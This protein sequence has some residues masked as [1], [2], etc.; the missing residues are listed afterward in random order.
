[1]NRDLFLS[2]LAM[3]SYNREYGAGV[4][5]AGSSI[6]S[7]GIR[8]RLSLGI[9][10]ATYLSWQAAGFYAL[11][12]SWNGETVI[13]YRGTNATNLSALIT[14]VFYGWPTGAGVFA[15]QAGL[16]VDFYRAVANAV[17]PNADLRATNI[18]TTGHSLGGG[19]AGMVATLY[20]RPAQVFD[21]MPFENAAQ[22]A[23]EASI[24]GE[25]SEIRTRIYGNAAPWVLNI[26]GVSG[27]A[28]EGE[29]L[30]TARALFSFSSPF[31][32]TTISTHDWGLA[33]DTPFT[34]NRHSMD[35][36]ILLKFAENSGVRYEDWHSGGTA[37]DTLD[38]LYDN[39]V[40]TA[41]GA[42]TISGAFS[43]SGDF[44]AALRR[45]LAYSAI[46]EGERPFGDTGISALFDGAANIGR[47]TELTPSGFLAD[48][49][50]REALTK[51]I[52][53]YAGALAV[54][55]RKVSDVFGVDPN[56]DAKRG[57]LSLSRDEGALALD[58]SK[59]IWKDVLGVSTAL[60]P[61]GLIELRS[62]LLTEAGVT[63]EKLTTYADQVWGATSSDIFDRLIMGTK[64]GS[65]TVKLEKR[66]YVT[67]EETGD[68][69]HIDLFIGSDGNEKITGTDFGEL[70][71]GGKGNDR[72]DGG[73]GQD[74]LLGGDGND[75]L[76]ASLDGE[77]DI[78]D[79]GDGQDT[80]VYKYQVLQ[81]ANPYG[82]GYGQGYSSIRLL[83]TTNSAKASM[84]DFGIQI[85]GLP[86]NGFGVDTL[87]NFEKASIEA[88]DEPDYLEIMPDA[89]VSGIDYIDLGGQPANNYDV[90]YLNRFTRKVT[91][92]L[93]TELVTFEQQLTILGIPVPGIYVTRNLK[94]KGAETVF[95]GSSDDELTSGNV[96]GKTYYLWGN[97][98]ADKLTG[99]AGRDIITGGDGNDQIDGGGGNDLIAGD[100]G[101]DVIYGGAGNDR[102]E[103]GKGSNILHGGDGDDDVGISS[104]DLTANN[105]I[106]GDGGNDSLD[107]GFGNDYLDGGDGDD[108][109][110]SAFDHDSFD[111]LVG[112]SG[113]D[114][115]TVGDGDTIVDLSFEDRGVTITSFTGYTQELNGASVR[116][117]YDPNVYYGGPI[118]LTYRLSGSTLFV[119]DPVGERIT[120]LN[121]SNG[122][123]GIFIGAGVTGTPGDDPLNGDDR[124]DIFTGGAGND[125]MSGGKG[126]DIYKFGLGHGSDTVFD[127]GPS[128][129]F[130]NSSFSASGLNNGPQLAGTFESGGD[131]TIYYD[132]SVTAG[133]IDVVQ[134]SATDVALRIRGTSDQ[135]I[136]QGMLGTPGAEI[137]HV[138]FANGTAWTYAEVIARMVPLPANQAP[139]FG[140]SS[141]L[142]ASI[143]EV[144][145]VTNGTAQLAATGSLAF[146]DPDA[147]DT[148]SAMINTVTASGQTNGAPSNATLRSWLSF[149]AAVE[150]VGATPGASAWTFSAPDKTFDYLSVGEQLVLSY[151]AKLSDSHGESFSRPVVVTITGANDR[152]TISAAT[153]A[154]L[155]VSEALNATASTTAL[156][157]SGGIAFADVDLSDVHSRSVTAV[158]VSGATSG[159]PAAG[160]LLPL[161]QLGALSE[162]NGTGNAP[163]TFSAEDR[164]FD[165]LGAGQTATLTYTVRV[166]DGRGGTV[167][168]PVVV[169][170][171]GSNDAPTTVVTGAQSVRKAIATRIEG[172]IVSDADAN[173]TASVKLTTTRGTIDATALN[174]ASVSGG[175]TKILTISGSVAQVNAT[176]AGLVY[177]SATTGADT[178]AVLTSDGTASNSQSIA[179]TVDTSAVH[180]PVIRAGSILSQALTERPSTTGS[181][182]A[183]T[184][185]G[186]LLFTDADIPN[187]HTASVTSVTAS[188][189]IAGLA[190]NATVK[191][192]LTNGA[193]I[194][195]NGVTNG[196]VPWSFAAPDSSFDYLGVAEAVTL[197]YVLKIADNASGATSQTVT[198]T[199]TGSNDGPAIVTTNTV[200]AGSVT[201]RANLTGSALLDT[202]AGA[203]KFSDADKTDI[204]NAQVLGVTANGV[205]T[206]LPSIAM[207]QSWLS[208]ATLTEPSGTTAG[209]Q[210]WTFT[211][212]DGALDG[213]AAGEQAVLTYA[214][215]LSDG[216]GGSFDQNVVVTITGSN[217]K[218]VAVIK[219]GYT[220]DNA[221]A[222]SV[223]LIE[224]LGGATDPDRGDTLTVTSVQGAVNGTVALVGNNAVFT[225]TNTKIGPASFT[226]TVA[227]GKGGTSTSTVSLTTTLRKIIGT[228]GN[229]VI[230]GTAIRAQIDGLAGNDTLTAGSAGDTLNGG[231]GD[232]ILTGGAG[233][234][235]IDGAAGNDTI[236]GKGGNDALSGGAGDDN[237]I[238]GTGDDVVS[239]GDGNDRLRGN[240]GNDA[241]DGGI[242]TDVAV[243]AGLQA[244]YSIVTNNGT[245]TIVD[246]APTVD[247]NDGTD[248]L[249][250]I[251]KVEFKG[252]VQFGIGAPVV[253]DLNG[254]G[255]KLIERSQSSVTFSW[256]GSGSRQRTGWVDSNDAILVYDRN[257]DGTVSGP[258]EISFTGDKPG[259]KSDLDG[260]S[261]FDSNNDGQLGSAD[262]KW[263]A[264][265]LWQDRNSN[266]RVDAGELRSLAAAGIASISLAKTA[267]NRSWAIGDNVTV[268]IGSFTRAD[269]TVGALGD[270]ALAYDVGGT[271]HTQDVGRVAVADTNGFD[272]LSVWA[273][274]FPDGHWWQSK[275]AAI[276]RRYAQEASVFDPGS[277]RSADLMVQ[278]MSMFGV[279]S[280]SDDAMFKVQA[281]FGV[282]PLA[283]LDRADRYATHS[284]GCNLV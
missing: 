278:A 11:A 51:I 13:S 269:G 52:V 193:L 120:I 176:L 192:W 94:V 130:V 77:D 246:N 46:D 180:A 36:L 161:L 71:A 105:Q 19:L 57:V 141:T 23:Y 15:T 113:A 118:A 109:L 83:S 260:L 201:E 91:A 262:N 114:Y 95:G 80:I 281:T 64:S 284:K 126:N 212:P 231:D 266:G 75:E 127:A 21:N 22:S 74:V 140:A 169:T 270:V 89:D 116:D 3:D 233:A 217:D 29:A 37:D 61:I 131:D 115:F 49:D 227:D 48:S 34:P 6:G 122:A 65:P 244:S 20:N 124:V 31:Q 157:G 134:I 174:G 117:E 28:V 215:R 275:S 108:S 43:G 135:I 100:D 160:A 255:V 265:Q 195:P 121:F 59:K 162:A 167:D 171:T 106:Y 170:V 27:S 10:N 69:Q 264:F 39:A 110:F 40:A 4:D 1:M 70:I 219:S 242:G 101:D 149:G 235:T 129:T 72:I 67:G 253:L 279:Q 280:G 102:I 210:S 166:D 238:G 47:V 159:L 206:P 147:G 151:D 203:I 16:S 60:E 84:G 96:A 33:Y 173:A 153:T 184:T 148:H 257:G 236:D 178:I 14:D 196:S 254:D 181:T 79:G 54:N 259:A 267:V 92:N 208:L 179:V 30:V 41:A 214:V 187:T 272:A 158:T 164:L 107:G 87:K 191:A 243:F 258:D 88:G 133:D 189:T 200:V 18:T 112:G 154:T 207:L 198:V 32:P 56:I 194:E 183:L 68:E 165:Y 216:K 261:A 62:A 81:T 249:V 9:D 223:P 163:W 182:V 125:T 119:R 274:D 99:L 2:I 229:D 199:I 185:G 245:T 202:V 138:R 8:S 136:L 177:T 53:Q 263:G 143:A 123:A 220:T 247:G 277:V 55:K 90:L 111:T 152:P 58:I 211:A 98:G 239:G 222:L 205:T 66:T 25:T 226:Y 221:T 42:N 85:L 209:T 256:D 230:T 24:P 232:D 228:A 82:G 86:N 146:T 38:A 271:Q 93:S 139:V 150:P 224:L 276:E 144:T 5:I 128:L 283:V 172:I 17:A 240:A 188:G 145:G 273:S 252:G 250:G 26:G 132:A 225:P 168:Q 103:G 218:P 156:T 12:Y 186:S 78:I 104:I 268:N 7:A 237:V 190:A 142:S 248:T 44:A 76:I 73:K 97:G 175:G 50:N 213:L 204:H 241:L 45:V 197:S 35:T 63:E 282:E 155:S 234:D 137:E 251:E